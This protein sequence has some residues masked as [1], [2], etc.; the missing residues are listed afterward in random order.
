MIC[1]FFLLPSL[2]SIREVLSFTIDQERNAYR[3]SKTKSSSLSKQFEV[4]KMDSFVMEDFNPPNRSL[5][6][7]GRKQ[8]ELIV[9]SLNVLLML[10]LFSISIHQAVLISSLQTQLNTMRHKSTKEMETEQM[11]RQTLED[12]M[13]N[14]TMKISN[15]VEGLAK[16]TPYQTYRVPDSEKSVFTV[17][18]N[19][20]ILLK[21]DLITNST[22]HFTHKGT[23]D[24]KALL[25]IPTG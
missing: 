13:N 12:K 15:Q 8:T 19:Q 25:L 22:W 23:E 14:V 6:N 21:E 20:P 1:Q 16:F 7:S 10:V 2:D 11:N 5:S 24:T 3:K 4:F 17:K 9:M 18:A